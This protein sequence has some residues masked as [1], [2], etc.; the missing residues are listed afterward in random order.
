M[1]LLPYKILSERLAVFAEK[2]PLLVLAGVVIYILSPIDLLPEGLIGPLGAFDDVLAG[3]AAVAVIKV[4]RR[5]ALKDKPAASVV[6]A[7]AAPVSVQ[8]EE[9]GREREGREERDN[10]NSRDDRNERGARGDREGR[11]DRGGRDRG[12]RDRGF[13]G[14]R[15][16]RDR[17][18]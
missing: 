1:K 14:G 4:A 7:A 11:G 5:K 9:R 2:R 15:P 3:F 18:R 6:K 10:Q 8:Q 12:G 16:R 13:Q 17:D